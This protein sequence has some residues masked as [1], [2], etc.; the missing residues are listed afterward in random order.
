[1]FTRRCRIGQSR[2]RNMGQSVNMGRQKKPLV[3]FTV[4]YGKS[5]LKIIKV[6][7]QSSSLTS[8]LDFFNPVY[9]CLIGVDTIYVS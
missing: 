9:G 1:M 5:P 4:C 3:N 6:L 8:T 2:T 7:G